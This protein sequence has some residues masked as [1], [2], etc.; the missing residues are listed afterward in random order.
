MKTLGG[1]CWIGTSIFD[2]WVHGKINKNLFKVSEAR[3]PGR[4]DE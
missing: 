1:A 3:E 4:P 2:A